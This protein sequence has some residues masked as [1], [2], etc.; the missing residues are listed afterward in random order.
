MSENKN[1]LWHL[2]NPIKLTSLEED[3]QADV[4]IVGGGYTGLSTALHLAKQNVD[5]VLLEAQDIGY[6]ASGRN[7]GLTN[8]GLWIMPKKTEQLLGKQRGR[9]LNQF[10]IDAPQYVDQ[11]ITEHSIDC[12]YTRNGTL[13]LAHSK[14]AIKYLNE[15]RKQLLEYG[16]DVVFL[17]QNE[18]YE[19]TKAEHYY[20][21]LKDGN[22]G[23][24]QPLK[25]CIGLAKLA[26]E[27]GVR[28]YNFSAVTDI[29]KLADGVKV[30]TSGG[31]VTAGNMV[32]ATN[33]YEEKLNYNNGL[34]ESLY[35]SQ[36]ASKPLS[37]MQQAECLPENNGCWDSG[38]VMRSFRT[39]ADGRLIVGTLGNIYTGKTSDFTTVGNMGFTVGNIGIGDARGLQKWV[40]HVV[41][42]TFPN[43]GELN[44]EFAWSGRIARSHNDIPQ[45]IEIDNGIFQILGYSGRGI[46]PA[47]VT[48]RVMADYLCG[49]IN[50]A[51]LPL[52]LNE[53]RHISFHKLR[54]VVYEVG[55]QMSHLSD[56]LIR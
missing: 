21:A 22:A 10:L 14:S 40:L 50:K 8:A 23:T 4:V 28:I 42:K 48:G 26:R 25:Y 31:N 46:S 45:I 30:F 47:T 11:L 5:V 55:C 49:K 17:D 33:A 34:F 54:E 20:G 52:P 12:D 18:A 56:F 9:K 53:A 16:A 39:D 36:L 7:V 51:E 43:L 29:E 2:A 13:H 3:L 24:L 32:L 19:Q 1:N 37:K 41:G 38:A 6:G 15:R 44:Y 35:Y 27:A